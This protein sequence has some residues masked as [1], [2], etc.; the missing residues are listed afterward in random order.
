MVSRVDFYCIASAA[1][2]GTRHFASASAFRP[3]GLNNYRRESSSGITEASQRAGLRLAF[4]SRYL[5]AFT[6]VECATHPFMLQFLTF[7]YL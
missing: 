5:S 3:L 4:A 7:I 1:T 2:S 6:G